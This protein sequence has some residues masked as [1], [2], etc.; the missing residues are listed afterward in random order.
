MKI[1]FLFF[2]FI[3]F[4]YPMRI[5]ALLPDPVAEPLKSTILRGIELTLNN[6]FEQADQLYQDIIDSLPHYPAGYFYKGAT[7]QAEMLDAENFQNKQAFYTLMNKTIQIADSLDRLGED[8]AWIYFYKG[9]AYLYRS[10]L[11]MKDGNWYAAYQDARKGVKTL[12]AAVQKDSTLYDAYLGIG[13]Y[14][15]WKS[16]KAKFL[17]WLPFISDQREQG[18]ELVSEAI[19]KGLFIEVVGKDQ[20]VW[21]LM[22]YGDIRQALI[23]ARENHQSYPTS[24]FLKWTLASAAFYAGEW[25]LSEKL[26]DE[27]LLEVRQLPVNNGFNEVDCLVRLA[28][29]ARENESWDK[30]LLYADEALRISMDSDTRE[31]AKNKLKKA[32]E[33]RQEAE[34]QIKKTEVAR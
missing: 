5:W 30:T 6:Q 11:K 31:R 15:Y 27:L 14:K 16:A 25:P 22:D 20:L 26:Y 2:N 33:I 32:L 10:F 3:L 29:I 8:N 19:Q 18:M 7:M 34:E 13:S 23:L 21:I 12:E 17:L 4:I 28:E 9:S 24:R 1:A